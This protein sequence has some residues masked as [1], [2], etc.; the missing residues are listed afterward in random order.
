TEVSRDGGERLLLG[1]TNVT[2]TAGGSFGGG[3][4]RVLNYG[5]ALTDHGLTLGTMPAGSSVTVQTSVAGQVNLINSAGL[6]LSFW[7]GDG[8]P[9]FNDVV[10]GGN[11]SW[12]LDGVDNNWTDAIGGVNAAYADGTF[13]IFAGTGG[14]VT[15]D[16]T[17]GAVTATGMQFASDS[18]LIAGDALTLVG[19]ESTI[20]VGD[21]TALGAG[22]T[23]TIDA[24]LTGTTQ[25]V[26]TD[27]GTLVL[28][29]ANSY[30]GGTL[31]N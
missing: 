11:G 12:H 28:S 7:D 19:P 21:G 9:K 20:R 15:V 17:G 23:A 18:Y 31:I 27:L 13:A 8:G 5:G 2:E 29:G 3:I 6:S 16:N 1:T 22:Y 10:N 30:T 14:T 4:Y 25:L 24:D 26:K